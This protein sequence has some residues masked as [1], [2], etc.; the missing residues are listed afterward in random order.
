MTWELEM[1]KMTSCMCT[2]W[3]ASTDDTIKVTA[4]E[5]QEIRLGLSLLGRVLA[6]HM[7]PWVQ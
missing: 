2:V 6:I 5:N 3:M 4:V 7:R 1:N